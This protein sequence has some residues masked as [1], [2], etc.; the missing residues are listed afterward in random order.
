MKRSLSS[1]RS[2]IGSGFRTRKAMDKVDIKNKF[3]KNEGIGHPGRIRDPYLNRKEQKKRDLFHQIKRNTKKIVSR[4]KI[5]DKSSTECLIEEK[6]GEYNMLFKKM[7]KKLKKFP[8]TKSFETSSQY[9]N[10]IRK[11]TNIEI[12]DSI[13]TIKPRQNSITRKKKTINRERPKSSYTRLYTRPASAITTRIRASIKES[14]FETERLSQNDSFCKITTDA[15]QRINETSENDSK[16]TTAQLIPLCQVKFLEKKIKI[17]KSIKREHSRKSKLKGKT[18]QRAQKVLKSVD[19]YLESRRERLVEKKKTKL[20]SSLLDLQMRIIFSKR[21]GKPKKKTKITKKYDLFETSSEEQMDELPQ[22]ELPTKKHVQSQNVIKK[23]TLHKGNQDKLVNLNLQKIRTSPQVSKLSDQSKL[24]S[25]QSVAN[26]IFQRRP[27]IR[28]SQTGL[29][30]QPNIHQALGDVTQRKSPSMHQNALRAGNMFRSPNFEMSTKNIFTPERK[31]S[32]NSIQKPLSRSGSDQSIKKQ[33]LRQKRL[34]LYK[35]SK[36]VHRTVA[37]EKPSLKRSAF[38]QS[39][40]EEET[41]KSEKK[42]DQSHKSKFQDIYLKSNNKASRFGRRR[43]SDGQKEEKEFRLS[44]IFPDELKG[45]TFDHQKSSKKASKT[46]EKRIFLKKSTPKISIT[47]QQSLSVIIRKLRYG[48]TPLPFIPVPTIRT[49]K[50]I[51]YIKFKEEIKTYTQKV[52]DSNNKEKIEFH[53]L[54]PKLNNEQLQD[55]NEPINILSLDQMFGSDELESADNLSI[56]GASSFIHMEGE[57]Q[58]LTK[59]YIKIDGINYAFKHLVEKP[60]QEKMPEL[61][62]SFAAGS[63]KRIDN[64]TAGLL[65]FRDFNEDE[66]DDFKEDLSD[67]P[68]DLEEFDDNVFL[69]EKKMKEYE[70]DIMF[71]LKYGTSENIPDNFVR[72]NV[73]TSIDPKKL[74]RQWHMDEGY[75]FQRRFCGCKPKVIFDF[76]KRPDKQTVKKCYDYIPLALS[77]KSNLDSRRYNRKQTK[78]EASMIHE[79][80]LDAED[81]DELL[82][83]IK[84]SQI[85]KKLIPL[86]DACFTLSYLN[87]CNAKDSKRIHFQVDIQNSYQY[88]SYSSQDPD[89]TLSVKSPTISIIKGQYWK[90]LRCCNKN[91]FKWITE[92]ILNRKEL[93]YQTGLIK[94]LT[95]TKLKREKPKMLEYCSDNSQEWNNYLLGGKGG[96]RYSYSY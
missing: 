53:G 70:K 8:T 44:K 6:K 34:S 3:V 29:I 37:V 12:T 26:K 20:D 63:L 87:Q 40:V 5:D 4:A 64:L 68:S 41:Q 28:P 86:I 65:H 60:K 82:E 94:I 61:D 85:S 22:Y 42:S 51:F 48:F 96:H 93:I 47:V 14:E 56:G 80:L 79:M 31:D 10:T 30:L 59:E 17:S 9:L 50:N 49:M 84:E 46:P 35:K 81:L 33:S 2:V 77:P 19:K 15:Y 16:F 32:N 90:K 55:L 71:K 78:F 23:R 88:R 13:A 76:L 89:I 95:K 11:S 18:K 69:D 21:K 57:A 24:T 52:V 74:Y 45:A 91:T 27:S 92:E 66:S 43:V 62:L 1:E 38:G 58:S 67:V 54:T 73:V 83:E 75:L 36:N 7:N 39:I 72:K 25:K